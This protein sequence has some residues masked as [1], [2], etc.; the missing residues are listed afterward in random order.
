MTMNDFILKVMGVPFVEKGRDYSGLDCYGL[1]RL[2]YHEIFGVDLPDYRDQYEDTGNSRDSRLA[3][4]ELIAMKKRKWE[5]V[6]K[7][8][9][10]DVALFNLG[11][12]PIHVGIM[13]D[14][15]NFLHCEKKIGTVIESISSLAWNRRLNG[16]F[17]L[18]QA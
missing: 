11:G 3:L 8:Q 9:P 17:R 5:P 13:I 12:M 18:C 2:S 4:S 6:A 10:M 7:Y 1:V 15:K 16:V 14:K